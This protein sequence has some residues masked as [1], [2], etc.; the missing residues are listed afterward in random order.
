MTHGHLD[1]EPEA[2]RGAATYLKSH[3]K[4]KIDP[5][6]LTPT[7]DWIWGVSNL[8]CELKEERG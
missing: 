4:A 6:L 7:W 8:I 2:Q 5:R 1:K 3:S